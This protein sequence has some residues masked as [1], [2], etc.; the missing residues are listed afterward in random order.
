[1][2]AFALSDLLAIVLV[3]DGG[4]NWGLYACGYILVNVLF[5]WMPIL[6]KTV[7]VACGLG[8]TF[9]WRS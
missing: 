3:V 6:E 4:L 1:M 9:I 2:A 7:Y 5:A 8:C